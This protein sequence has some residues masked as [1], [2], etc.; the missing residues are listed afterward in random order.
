MP[1]SPG[2]GS[3]GHPPKPRAVSEAICAWQRV[4]RALTLF[5]ARYR[6]GEVAGTEVRQL[7]AQQAD[8]RIAL[9]EI[10]LRVSA[11]SEK[12]FLPF[13]AS[14][15]VNPPTTG[16]LTELSL[17]LSGTRNSRDRSDQ[18][19]GLSK[20]RRIRCTQ[21]S[22]TSDLATPRTRRRQP[23][24][25]A[26]WSSWKEFH[27][28][29][30]TVERRSVRRSRSHYRYLS[31][32][33]SPKRQGCG[34]G[35]RRSLAR[36]RTLT[37]QSSRLNR[38]LDSLA[39][40]RTLSSRPRAV[41][42][43]L[44]WSRGMAETE[45]SLNEQFRLGAISYLVFLD[46]VARLDDV[47]LRHIELQRLHVQSRIEL[48]QLTGD[49]RYFPL[50]P[51]K[52]L[53]A[54]AAEG[55]IDRSDDNDGETHDQLRNERQ[56]R[57]PGVSRARLV[58]RADVLVNTCCPATRSHGSGNRSPTQPRGSLPRRHPCRAGIKLRPA[59]RS[60]RV[61]GQIV[62]SPG[63]HPRD[64]Q[65]GAWNRPSSSSVEPGSR[66]RRGQDL[67]GSPLSRS[68][69]ISQRSFAWVSE[70][71]KWLE[72]ASKPAASCT[73]WKASAESSS[74]G[75][76]TKPY[77]P[78]SSVEAIEVELEDLGMTSENEIAELTIGSLHGELPVRAVASGVILELSCIERSAGSNPGRPLLSIGTPDSLELDLQI[79]P[80]LA[81]GIMPS[82]QG[83]VCPGRRDASCCD[84]T[85]ADSGPAGRPDNTVPS[86]FVPRSTNGGGSSTSGD[87][88]RR[89]ADPIDRA[90]GAGLSS[91]SVDRR[92]FRE[93]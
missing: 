13:S 51:H 6:L 18:P 72:I 37:S 15:R 50:F 5:E 56:P 61:V 9:T 33:A 47:R 17:W 41:S 67:D 42:A 4:E 62:R 7:E 8:D 34:E 45:Y 77:V 64:A 74:N 21:P 79:Q 91:A 68:C 25:R 76:N 89:N 82:D 35:T 38:D 54:R 24:N 57:P 32:A 78:S 55:R 85:V 71:S 28:L 73:N 52:N 69:T 27:S 29:N 44:P 40:G 31:A 81:D 23:A 3:S 88:R 20:P 2:C 49:S 60:V 48:G 1:T 10:Q 22:S 11:K 16:S 30:N 84:A 80:N 70:R 92:T 39:P 58:D 36:S 65:P 87:V 59:N 66:V 53:R 19:A 90:S 46:G 63:R 86:R 26:S 93:R 14:S 43:R 83:T 12:L 75:V